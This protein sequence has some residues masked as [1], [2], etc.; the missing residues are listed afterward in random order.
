M[1]LALVSRVICQKALSPFV[2]LLSHHKATTPNQA[3]D[4]NGVAAT[5][6]DSRVGELQDHSLPWETLVLFDSR[7]ESESI[8]RYV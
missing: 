3:S 1:R 2:S 8:K 7:I 4:G 5:W 6:A